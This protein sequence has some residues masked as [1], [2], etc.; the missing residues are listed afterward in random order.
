MNEKDLS[1]NCPHLVAKQLLN[2][3]TISPQ[4]IGLYLT[5]N[6]KV[7][8]AY[9]EL[10]DFRA[11]RIDEALRQLFRQLGL[12]PESQQI[13][14]ILWAFAIRFSEQNNVSEETAHALAHVIVI[15]NTD[16]QLMRPKSRYPRFFNR[17]A[18]RKKE[19]VK[20]V[21]GMVGKEW[22]K[23][24]EEIYRQ[25]KKEPLQFEMERELQRGDWQGHLYYLKP[26]EKIKLWCVL[27]EDCLYCYK[28]SEE[29][30]MIIPSQ[31]AIFYKSTG[32]LK[33]IPRDGMIASFQ[34]S[35]VKLI[36]RREIKLTGMDITELYSKVSL[37]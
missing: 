5:K 37:Y 27:L 22:K 11:L 33:I 14:R 35:G 7:L 6:A 36:Q 12:P 13:D 23:S 16:L 10:F 19:F 21:S 20:I 29:L 8:T 9:I 28:D 1:E 25:I 30:F 34:K 15:L 18:I 26:L 32:L 31:K 2:S 4:L 24:L 3:L 17:E